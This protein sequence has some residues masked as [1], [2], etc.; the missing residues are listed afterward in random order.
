M[1]TTIQNILGGLAGSLALTSLHE[2]LAKKTDKAPR[3]DLVGEEAV[4]ETANALGIQSPHGKE[5]FN[6]TL[7]AD[8]TSNALYYSAA[9]NGSD[10]YIVH[11]AAALGL[12]AGIGAVT[13]TG[14]LDL[15]DAPVTK[16]LATKAMTVGYYLVGGLVAG[17]VIKRLRGKQ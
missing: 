3:I 9:G 5:L 16:N 8:L 17:M 15:E 1:R 13:L 7:A 12:L 14:E 10:Q 4:T 6:A 11:R 2:W